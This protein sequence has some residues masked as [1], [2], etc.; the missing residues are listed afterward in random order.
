MISEKIKINPEK[1]VGC[2]ICQLTCSF[3]YNKT[4][5]P[6]KARIKI[7]D[8]YG[9]TPKIEFTEE[10]VQCGKCAS[11]CLYGALELIEVNSF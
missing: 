3:T 7:I 11:N 1:C 8:L 2:R 4:F 6:T 5:N 9:L 10:C